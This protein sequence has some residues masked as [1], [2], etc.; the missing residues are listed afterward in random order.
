MEPDFLVVSNNMM[1]DN[2]HK[3]KCREFH[4]NRRKHWFTES[5]VEHWYRFPREAV[6]CPPWR[7][8][9]AFWRWSC[10]TCSR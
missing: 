3:P 10:V 4:L 7:Y 9:N 8:S 1:R 6:E 2:S 5:L